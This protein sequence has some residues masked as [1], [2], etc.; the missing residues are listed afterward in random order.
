MVR[1]FLLWWF[2]WP[3]NPFVCVAGAFDFTNARVYLASLREQG[4]PE[5]TINHLLAASVGRVLKEFPMANA[6]VIGKRIELLEQVGLAMPV[7][8]AGHVTETRELSMAMVAQI[9]ILS[10]RQ[11]A[12]ACRSSVAGERAGRSQRPVVQW[13]NRF[14]EHMP[15]PLMSRGLDALDWLGRRPAFAAELQKHIPVSAC[16]SNPG[17]A[18]REVE[19]AVLRAVSFAPPPRLNPVGTIWAVSAVQDEVIAEEGQ[20][21]VRPMLPVAL[22]FDHRLFDG[23]MAGKVLTRFAELIREPQAHFGA[24][25]ETCA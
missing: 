6:R 13:V 20:P 19:G 3:A 23:I 4:G 7:S 11:V 18:F 1:K 9:D 22:V 16:L 10:L 12:D 24:N 5:V 25:G 15:L 8:L 14:L 2:D 21:V 17:A